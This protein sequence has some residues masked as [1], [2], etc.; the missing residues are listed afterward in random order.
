MIIDSFFDT[1][2]KRSHFVYLVFITVS[3]IFSI[4]EIFVGLKL[5]TINTY[6]EIL[7][8]VNQSYLQ[9]SFFGR[10]S[11]F[12]LNIQVFDIIEFIYNLFMNIQF[13]EMLYFIGIILCLFTKHKKIGIVNMI[14]VLTTFI[15]IIYVFL[16]AINS[17]SVYHLISYIHM[18]GIG[19]I[20]IYILL[21]FI[22]VIQFIKTFNGYLEALKVEVIIEEGN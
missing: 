20:V 7:N 19:L 2:E 17:T 21:M 6:E 12:L 5:L 18:I 4:F 15:F 11:L 10:N 16:N 9:W 22:N 1:F 14:L 13:H 3:I 8:L